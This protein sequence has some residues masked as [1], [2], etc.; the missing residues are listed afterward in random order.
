MSSCCCGNSNVTI[1][2]ACSGAADVGSL[3]DLAARKLRDEKIGAMSCLAAVGAGLSGFIESAKAAD[4]CI[5][6]D[7]CQVAC[8]KK[9]LEK[10]GVTPKSFI[11]TEMGYEK[12]KT[13]VNEATV[14][15]AV[16]KIKNSICG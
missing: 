5:T 11:I 14:N 7:G 13:N 6:I 1:N 9:N 12:G 10:I 2:Y 4:Q 16:L 8:A 15:E 3:S